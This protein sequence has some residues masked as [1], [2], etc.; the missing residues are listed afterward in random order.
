[1]PS[2]QMRSVI[3]IITQPYQPFL[4]EN[5]SS[6]IYNDLA[7]RFPNRQ[8]VEA[9][10]SGAGDAPAFR[11]VLDDRG[12]EFSHGFNIGQGALCFPPTRSCS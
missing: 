10:L 1:M 9:F 3:Y 7:E 11:L 8:K 12:R 6:N 5:M 2:A 4:R